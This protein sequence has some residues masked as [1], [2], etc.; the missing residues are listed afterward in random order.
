MTEN[1]MTGPRP[2]VAR[3][4]SCGLVQ[5]GRVEAGYLSPERLPELRRI[6][7]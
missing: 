5:H 7:Q 1:A 3:T 6:A 4:E 2:A